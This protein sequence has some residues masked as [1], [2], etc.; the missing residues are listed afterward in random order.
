[1][2]G[3]WDMPLGLSRVAHLHRF[4]LSSCE[5]TPARLTD[6]IS[7]GGLSRNMRMRARRVAYCDP[8]VSQLGV[9]DII[10]H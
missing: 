2:E 10:G 9:L 3:W 1:M 6:E 4:P 5:V 7:R 8:R